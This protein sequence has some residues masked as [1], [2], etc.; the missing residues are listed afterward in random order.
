MSN[1][2]SIGE[3]AKLCQM[4][5][6]AL[7]YYDKI[8]LIKPAYID[9]ETGYRYYTEDQITAIMRIKVLRDEEFPLNTVEKYL[10]TGDYKELRSFYFERRK[11]VSEQIKRLEEIQHSV[12]HQLNAFEEISF[13]EKKEQWLEPTVEIKN[14]QP[15]HVVFYRDEIP[16]TLK[17]LSMRFTRVFKIMNE[18]NLTVLEPYINIFYTKYDEI[19][20][21]LGEREIDF[22]SCMLINKPLE[23][24][25]PFT[26]HIDGGL[27]ATIIHRGSFLSSV[28]YYHHLVD[29]I[30]K[31]NYSIAGPTVKI[32]HLGIH[33]TKSPKDILSEL[34]IKIENK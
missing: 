15:R 30:E 23:E 9:E 33:H 25:L 3:M 34:Q 24:E 26:R 18:A 10:K 28:D 5:T 20:F 29:W 4:S 2:Y 8:D 19:L 11:T 6:K 31:N 21:E 17:N 27:Y 22:A 16:F 14:L 7:R 1:Y 12:E 32:Y 13:I